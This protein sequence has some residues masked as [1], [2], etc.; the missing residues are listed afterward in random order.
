MGRSVERD[1]TSARPSKDGRVA[2]KEPDWKA[3]STDEIRMSS[4]V[5]C[6]ELFQKKNSELLMD[7][8][9]R[10]CRGNAVSRSKETNGR[11]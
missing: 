3:Q 4:N 1:L 8:N 7:I 10:T 11:Y 9:G 2:R 5:C 6:E